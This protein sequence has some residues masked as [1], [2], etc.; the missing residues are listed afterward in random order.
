M[1]H[2]L[3]Q[4]LTVSGNVA[5]RRA[6]VE[7]HGPGRYEPYAVTVAA[8]PAGGWL[9]TDPSDPE[10]TWRSTFVEAV[11]A[12]IAQTSDVLADRIIRDVLVAESSA[13]VSTP[14]GAADIC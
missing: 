12:A 1:T 9:V 11:D 14:L 3:T 7:V 4:R 13:P 6:T 5:D 10:P 8:A 2:L